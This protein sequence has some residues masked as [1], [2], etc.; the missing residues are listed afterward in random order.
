[1]NRLIINLLLFVH[2]TTLAAETPYAPGS[3]WQIFSW[4]DP[5]SSAANHDRN[6]EGEFVFVVYPGQEA[7]LQVADAGWNIE[8]IAVF[9]GYSY[10]G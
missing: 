6:V 4:V 2:I 10:T 7:R 9:N 8:K 1:M 5:L 3:G